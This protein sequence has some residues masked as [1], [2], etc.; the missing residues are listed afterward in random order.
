MR[1]IKQHVKKN[2]CLAFSRFFP[3]LLLQRSSLQQQYPKCSFNF[4]IDY[5]I[6]VLVQLFSLRHLFIVESK[7][8]LGGEP[9]SQVAVGGA[10]R[11]RF[12][13]YRNPQEIAVALEPDPIGDG[14]T[15][16]GK[17]PKDGQPHELF[18]V[19]PVVR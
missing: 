10:L 11:L 8:S 12:F 3:N 19:V 15:E 9:A 13:D 6:A 17:H 4:E 5:G 2:L 18:R 1:V 14:Q 7:G 16:T